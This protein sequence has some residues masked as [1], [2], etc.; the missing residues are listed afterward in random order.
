M[1]G[2]RTRRFARLG[3]AKRKEPASAD[4]F[5]HFGVDA[6]PA[7]AVPAATDEPSPALACP[8]CGW[9]RATPFVEACPLCA[10]VPRT[11][12]DEGEADDSDAAPGRPA[13]LDGAPT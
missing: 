6:E 12:A 13:D 2:D 8:D 9:F 1:A 5:A 4:L 10:A 11:A 3:P 7:V